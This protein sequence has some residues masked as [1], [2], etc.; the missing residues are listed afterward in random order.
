MD[1]I[2]SPSFLYGIY[3]MKVFDMI[4]IKEKFFG[5][6]QISISDGVTRGII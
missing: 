1:C 5:A 6:M 2:H 3:K 4:F